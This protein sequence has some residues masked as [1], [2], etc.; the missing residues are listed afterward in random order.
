[1]NSIIAIPEVTKK[2]MLT[3]QNLLKSWSQEKITSMQISEIT[4]W[5]NSLIRHDLWLL[6]KFQSQLLEGNTVFENETFKVVVSK[7]PTETTA[8]TSEGE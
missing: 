3:L 5:N 1:M 4:G 6:R 2:R 8:S 7:K